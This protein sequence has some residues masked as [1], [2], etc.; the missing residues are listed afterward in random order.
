MSEGQ[1][2]SQVEIH[3]D[4]LQHVEDGSSRMRL[5]SGVSAAVAFLLII[6]Y[7]SQLALPLTGTTSVTVSLTDPTIIATEIAVLAL[8]V[9]WLY[10][11]VRNYRFT[12]KLAKRIA[13]ARAA[14]AVM[15][16]KLTS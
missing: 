7:I 1:K 8:S 5:L 6:S 14:E 15:E 3:E 12:T 11:G 16:K 10:V 4:F 9:A 13:A 2:P